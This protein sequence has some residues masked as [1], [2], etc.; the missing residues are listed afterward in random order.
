MELFESVDLV[1]DGQCAARSIVHHDSVTIIDDAERHSAVTKFQRRKID[2]PGVGNVNGRLEMAAG[3]SSVS[4]VEFAP[5]LGIF[6]S[7]V[8]PMRRRGRLRA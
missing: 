6:L 8:A 7:F 1:A 2:L 5:V 3:A 4:G